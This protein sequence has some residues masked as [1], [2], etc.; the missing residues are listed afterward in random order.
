MMMRKMIFKKFH[1]ILKNSFKKDFMML[2]QGLIKLG[3]IKDLA[4]ITVNKHKVFF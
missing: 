2:L 3:I 1:L 4:M